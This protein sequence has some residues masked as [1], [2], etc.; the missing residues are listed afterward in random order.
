MLVSGI[1]QSD[2]TIPMHVSIPF[3]ILFPF[4]LLHTI[5]QS[6]RVT[7]E[8]AVRMLGGATSSEG[9][10]G[11]GGATSKTAASHGCWLQFIT[12]QTSPKSC[13]GVFITRRLAFP[14]MQDP[15]K[16]KEEGLLPP[17]LRRHTP[18]LPPYCTL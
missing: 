4:R 13:L 9:L 6:S 12:T 2:S 16:N 17:G 10:T 1:Q 18:S 3:Q 8:I 15:R 11:A 14:R 7:H 5:Q